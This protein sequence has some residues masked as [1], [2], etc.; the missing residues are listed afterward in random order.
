MEFEGQLIT[1]YLKGLRPAM[2]DKMG[3]HI[4]HIL[5]EANNLAL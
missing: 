2:C 4:I 3:V 5:T 1:Q